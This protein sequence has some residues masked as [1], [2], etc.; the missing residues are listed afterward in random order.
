M[1]RGAIKANHESQF[2]GAWVPEAMLALVDRAVDTTDTD[3]SKFI[4]AAIKEK[5]GRELASAK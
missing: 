2:V 3:R 1:K 4:R 5:L